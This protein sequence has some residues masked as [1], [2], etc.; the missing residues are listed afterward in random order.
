MCKPTTTTTKKIGYNGWKWHQKMFVC[1]VHSKCKQ[2]CLTSFK[3]VHSIWCGVVR[4]CDVCNLKTRS[5]PLFAVEVTVF[6]CLVNSSV[7]VCSSVCLPGLLWFLFWPL[8]TSSKRWIRSNGNN[9]KNMT[10]NK[11]TPRTHKTMITHFVIVL[12]LSVDSQKCASDYAN[13]VS[14]YFQ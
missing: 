9:R 1:R 5:Q 2:N 14:N 13:Y 8:P 6:L 11:R 3:S 4:F 7:L 10:K 12:M